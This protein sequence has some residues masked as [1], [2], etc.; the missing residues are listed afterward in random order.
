MKTIAPSIEQASTSAAHGGASRCGPHTLLSVMSCERHYALRKFLVPRM[1]PRN[2]LIGT[3]VHTCLAYRDASKLPIPP[4]WFLERSME[5]AL[6]KDAHGQ[7]DELKEALRIFRQYSARYAEDPWTPIAIELELEAKIS[8]IYPDAPEEAR[9]L[10]VTSRY[11]RIVRAN[12][13]LLIPD[14]KTTGG[15]TGA[16]LPAW[17][18]HGN[19]YRSSFQVLLNLH[20]ART[21]KNQEILG[22]YVRGYW[23]QRIKQRLPF[24]EDRNPVL[25]SKLAYEQ[26]PQ[27]AAAYALRKRDLDARLSRGERPIPNRGACEGRYGKCD[28]YAICYANSRE[29]AGQIERTRFRNLQEEQEAKT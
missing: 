7:H 8:E 12:G 23:I 3:L 14:I 25:I 21:K 16:R 26:C 19:E 9:D 18:E 20:I 22:G 2:R 17:S 5:E 27:D 1:E 4:K 6:E 15:E 10:V 29:D 28:F 11:D 13:V 24:D